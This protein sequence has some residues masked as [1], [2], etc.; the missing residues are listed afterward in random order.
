[1][2]EVLDLTVADLMS[3]LVITV[4]PEGVMQHFVAKTAR[5]T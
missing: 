5:K 2:R 4:R 3:K 1:M